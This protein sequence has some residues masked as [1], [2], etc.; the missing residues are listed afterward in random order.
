MT[1]AKMPATLFAALAELQAH[2]PKIGKGNT[3]DVKNAQGKKLYDYKYADL[4]DVS[5]EMLPR[6]GALGLA[7]TSRPTMLDG[8][9]VLAYSLTH[10]SGD[11]EDGIYPLPVSGTPQQVGSAITYARRYC[12]CAVTGVAPDSDDD[13][14]AAAEVGHR[15]AG[16]VFENAAP[17]RPQASNGNSNGAP[18][19]QV[20]RPAAAAQPDAAPADEIDPDAQELANDA[21]GCRS[22]NE[23]RK[24]HATAR[25]KGKLRA[26]VADPV[27]GTKGGLA[28]YLNFRKK[29]LEELDAAWKELN[30]AM[31]RH[32]L[33]IGEMEIQ[34]KRKTG[35]DS[36]SATPVQIREFIASLDGVA[37]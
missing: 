28:G 29:V 25:E 4:A 12:L 10:V 23:L 31:G 17:A 6:L 30:G 37:A 5:Q 8:N 21:H 26:F 7:F 27:T 14:A 15:S 11:R 36:E 19:G 20:A 3:A 16:D 35:A 24:I 33:D 13:D 18:R 1:E 34:I 9:F 32:H 2:L 22:V